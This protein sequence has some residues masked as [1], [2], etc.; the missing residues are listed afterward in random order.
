MATEI[1]SL[2]DFAVDVEF[3]IRMSSLDIAP[4]KITIPITFKNLCHIAEAFGF[5]PKIV[6]VSETFNP[7]D[8]GAIKDGKHRA[9]YEIGNKIA[10]AVG[11]D[12][13]FQAVPA[14]PDIRRVSY[15][16]LVFFRETDQSAE[17]EGDED[18][19]PALQQTAPSACGGQR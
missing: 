14:R 3:T 18:E 13:I 1:K 11:L 4:H 7:R 17:V 9:R 10:M 2:K 5:K 19:V 6:E 16:T 15:R 12:E 8:P